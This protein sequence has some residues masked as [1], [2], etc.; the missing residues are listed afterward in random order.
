MTVPVKASSNLTDPKTD[1]V[2]QLYI[3]KRGGWCEVIA[4]L[5]VPDIWRA[6]PRRT[7]KTIIRKTDVCIVAAAREL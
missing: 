6:L 4:S 3:R 1:R 5:Q 2:C 7:V